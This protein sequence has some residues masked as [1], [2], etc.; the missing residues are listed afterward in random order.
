MYVLEILRNCQWVA[1]DSCNAERLQA[2]M[3]AYQEQGM[4]VRYRRRLSFWQKL[5]NLLGLSGRNDQ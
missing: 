1:L 4:T 2:E 5:L 3:M